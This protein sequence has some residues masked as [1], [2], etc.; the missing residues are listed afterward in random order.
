[1]R[2]K[3]LCKAVAFVMWAD[4]KIETDEWNYAE[5][6]FKKY[7]LAF[8]E[9]KAIIDEHLELL[10]DEDEEKVEE[11]DEDLDIG[12]IDF[13]DEVDRYE[14]L[15]EL[16]GLVVSDGVVDFREVDVLHTIG[17]AINAA[18]QMVTL[19][20]LKAANKDGVTIAID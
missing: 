5:S 14:V 10:L 7:K 13:G 6:I 18:P 12:I 2:M 8:D 19:S 20:L 4:E 16:A 1:M 9:A 15:D 3:A 17:N 11:K